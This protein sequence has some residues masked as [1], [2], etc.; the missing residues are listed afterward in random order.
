VPGWETS[1]FTF[2]P[3]KAEGGGASAVGKEG[4]A[5]LIRLY[6]AVYLVD[7]PARAGVD[8]RLVC[9]GDDAALEARMDRAAPIVR[10]WLASQETGM[11]AG[12]LRDAVRHALADRTTLEAMT[13]SLVEFVDGEVCK[14]DRIFAGQVAKE[15]ALR[16]WLSEALLDPTRDDGWAWLRAHGQ[17]HHAVQVVVD[18]LQG[19]LV[20]ALA[21][22]RAGHPF[23]VQAAADEAID[24]ARRPSAPSTR[25]GPAMSTAFLHHVA[26]QGFA[27]QLPAFTPILSSPGYRPHGLSTTPTISV[28]NL[29]IAMTG[30]PVAGPRS[31]GVPNFHFVDR[32]YTR[33]GEVQGRP[34]Y[35]YGND[36]L[37]LT[38]LTRESGMT[39][40][41][42]RF[43][44]LVTM[45]CSGQYDEAAGYSF[46]GFLA[47]AIGERVRDFGERRCMAELA[48]RAENERRVAA[49]REDLL[50][51]E[52][53]L[54]VPHRP[55]E[56]YD[57]WAQHQERAAVEALVDE[58]AGLAPDAMPD[59]LL[60]YDPWPDHFA[61]AK[62]PFA[63]E[64]IG[65]TG[66]IVRLDHWLG[67][68]DDVYT[69][70]GVH[71]RTL[72]G[73]AGDHGLTPVRWLVSPEAEFVEG[74]RRTGVE[75]VVKKLSSDEGEGPKL[76][77]RLRPPSMK[78]LDVVVASTA[79]GNYMM[80]FFVDQGA[81]WARQ[82]ILAELRAL[83]TLGGKKVDVPGELLRRLG[84]SLDYLVLRDAPC[85][86]EGG[87]VRVMG[88]RH[89]VQGDGTIERRGDRIWYGWNAADVLDLDVLSPYDAPGDEEIAEARAILD[90][91]RTALREAPETWCTE[92]EW[93][94]ATRL[95]RRP[96]A[97]GQLAHLYDT[98]RAGTVNLFPRDG[99]GYNTTVPGRHA[100]ES[101]HEKDAFVGLWGTP[102]RA[103]ASPSPLTTNGSVPM[104]LAEWLSGAPSVAG[105]D[106]WGWEGVR[107]GT[108]VRCRPRPARYPRAPSRTA[109]W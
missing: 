18:G 89:G 42:E 22:G 38:A 21:S 80:D 76:T 108:R 44:S 62:G 83:R 12:D 107:R 46:D 24:A 27:G 51:R 15:R 54:H 30:A 40:M 101:F 41:F 70:S 28:R 37:R 94:A 59:Y 88:P 55:W 29:P 92:T 10:E 61:H 32:T 95:N 58:L 36:A 64:I 25:A 26:R 73:M 91:C 67:R 11:A 79:G 9:D 60:V 71:D 65:P 82:P 35:F 99:V 16:A 84:D 56:L 75:L 81:G 14:H 8:D 87:A 69:A 103:L 86:P 74:L 106:G 43:D 1:L 17:R 2:A 23:L 4:A 49:L 85:T 77:H 48:R 34:W 6:D 68:L 63:D 98:D 72:F 100:G 52:A 53:L 96:D 93:K 105:Q 45:S 31:T 97:V 90:Q 66:E 50:S 13:L 78:G 33:N 3:P 109:R 47:L 7:A 19:H 57:R 39:T 5:A 20:A 102:V 104:A